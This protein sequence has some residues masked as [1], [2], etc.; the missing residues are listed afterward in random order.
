VKALAYPLAL[1]GLGAACFATNPASDRAEVVAPALEAI[2]IK[3]RSNICVSVQVNQRV[4][5]TSIIAEINSGLSGVLASGLEQLAEQRGISRFI[6]YPRDKPGPRP[7]PRFMTD[8]GRANRSC[9]DVGEDIYVTVAYLPRPGGTPFV[10]DYRVQQ[11]A[12][13][14]TGS[15]HR[16]IEDEWRTGAL[17]RR[18]KANPIAVAIGDDLMARA[19]FIFD[20]IVG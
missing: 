16:D 18:H 7:E 11:G 4:W 15:V 1:F 17:V 20:L 5:P 3:E 6:P 9:R 8:Y 10:F 14:R 12:I 19:P 2:V 13:V